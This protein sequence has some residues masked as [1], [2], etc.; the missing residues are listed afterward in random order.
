MCFGLETFHTYVYGKHVTVQNDHKLLEVIQRKPTHAAL[1]QLQHMLLR[2]QKYEYTIQYIPG[3]DMV[4]ADRLS[5][6][7]SHKNNTP[8]ELHQNIQTLNFNHNGLNIIKG[9][10]ERDLVH[11]TVYRLTLN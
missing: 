2:L 1:P 4:L 8:I 3:K 5:R 9:A 6:F 11:S 7:P 10:I